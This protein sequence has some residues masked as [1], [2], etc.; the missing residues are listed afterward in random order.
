VDVV[1][2]GTRVRTAAFDSA[3][4]VEVITGERV[5]PAGGKS[6]RESLVGV[7]GVR[8]NARGEDPTFSG[9]EVRGLSTNATSGANALI[10]LDGIPQRRLSFGGPY[11]G[12]LPYDAVSRI[13]L[14]KGPLSSQYGRGSL[15]GAIQLFTH[16][17]SETFGARARMLHEL[18]TNT[19]RGSLSVYGPLPLEDTTFSVTGSGTVSNGWQPRSNARHG[20]VYVHVSSYLTLC[21]HVRLTVGYYDAEEQSVSPVLIDEDGDRLRGI[22][23]DANLA[24]PDQN[25]LDIAETRLGINYTHDFSPTMQLG[26]TVARWAADTGWKMGRPSDAPGS[27][28][29]V[30]RPARDL[31]WEESSWLTEI[32]LQESYQLSEDIAGVV[33]G[34]V[35]GEILRWDSTVQNISAGGSTF[36]EGIPIDLVNMDEPPRSAWVRGAATTRE[37]DE[38]DRGVFIS[39]TTTFYDRVTVQGGLRYD[40]YR[41]SQRNLSTG[42]DSSV[43]DS[44]LSPAA[45]LVLHLLGGARKEL[46]LNLY[47]SWGRG[48]SP[49]FRAVSNA[50]IVEVDPETSE[51]VEAGVK[52]Q[53]WRGLLS[54]T[55]AAYQLD[56]KD[57]VGWNP[58]SLTQENIGDWQIR[59]V[60]VSVRGRP[61]R[62]LSLFAGATLRTTSIERDDANPQNEGNRIPFVSDIMTTLG[63]SYAPDAGLGGDVG[64]RTLDGS[65]ADDAN[66]IHLPGAWLLDASVSYRWREMTVTGFTKNLLDADYYSAVFQG[67]RNGAAFAG[68]P[69]TYGAALTMA[70]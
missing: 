8:L 19:Q 68:T 54:A 69:R 16:P 58:D 13:E 66:R 9:I 22:D 61:V 14:V 64:L 26:V 12:A 46:G 3:T 27:G 51:S 17:G 2:T 50:E 20:D 70:Y 36:A 25:A 28:T 31:D 1:V 37:T 41:R 42:D 23:R 18:V 49:V 40:Q 44:A 56:R 57:V 5:H 15:A 29:V 55:V 47:G 43:S 38:L 65:F 60:E 39:D 35:S 4:D 62:P 34:G 63:A 11:M 48:F 21:D 53:A 52:F 30:T 7:T 24:V 10:L 6:F 67:V 33:T 45:G 32:Q 59:G